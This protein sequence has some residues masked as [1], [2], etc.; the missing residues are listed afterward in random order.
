MESV[1]IKGVRSGIILALDAK[2]PYEQLQEEIAHKFDEASAFLGKARMGLMIRGKE[3]TQEQEADVLKI[4]AE[5]TDLDIV[6]VIQE[7]GSLDET[8]EKYINQ[9]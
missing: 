6:C 7:N 3:L 9:K 1:M 4:I 5:H 2:Q 8:F